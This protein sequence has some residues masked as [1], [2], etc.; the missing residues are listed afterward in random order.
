MVD[1]E[2]ACQRLVPMVDEAERVLVEGGKEGNRQKPLSIPLDEIYELPGR[3][4]AGMYPSIGQ[5][6][7]WGPC[8]P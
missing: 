2:N 5:H 3:H 7:G 8:D 4:G 6:Q 1:K